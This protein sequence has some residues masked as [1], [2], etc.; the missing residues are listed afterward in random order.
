MSSSESSSIHQLCY[1]GAEFRKY[2]PLQR[3]CS[4]C[5][6]PTEKVTYICLKQTCYYRCTAFQP[7]VICEKCY[8]LTDDTEYDKNNQNF[9]NSKFKSILKVMKKEMKEIS[10]LDDKR[11][12]LDKVYEQ[13]CLYWITEGM[14]DLMFP[15]HSRHLSHIFS[16]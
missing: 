6:H 7:F 3:R 16:K 5:C 15:L 10:S 2:G 14:I 8:N 11:R 1:C 12:F 9:I 13:Q 4:S